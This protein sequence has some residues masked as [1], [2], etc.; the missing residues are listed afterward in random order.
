[1]VLPR[2][3][4]PFHPVWLHIQADSADGQANPRRNSSVVVRSG[5]PY[6]EEEG[7]WFCLAGLRQGELFWSRGSWVFFLLSDRGCEKHG[8]KTV[9]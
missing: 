9:S 2:K 6:N 4:S 5:L 1:M 3:M 7:L 8:T